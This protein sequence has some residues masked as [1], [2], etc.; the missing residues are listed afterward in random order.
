[1]VKK[2]Y[3]N[4]PPI[5]EIF[6]EDHYSM[7]DTWHEPSDT[8]DTCILSAIGYLVAENDLYYWV[9]CT[10]EMENGNYQGGTAVLKKCVTY[11]SVLV[12]TRKYKP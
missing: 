11:Y 5:V 2:K 6:W 4:I 1:M 12:E 3:P 9:A 8:H 7:G 10:Y